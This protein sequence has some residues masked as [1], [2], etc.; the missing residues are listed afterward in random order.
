MININNNKA[1]ALNL[2]GRSSEA[3]LLLEHCL[4]LKEK[5]TMLKSIGDSYFSLGK[6]EKAIQSY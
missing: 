5:D 2:L 3:I 6:L 1:A 4:K